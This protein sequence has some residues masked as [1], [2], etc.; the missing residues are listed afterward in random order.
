VVGHPLQPT[1]VTISTH[2]NHVHIALILIIV[3]VI[4]HLGDNSTILLVSK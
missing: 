3:L 2:M 1:T 4:V